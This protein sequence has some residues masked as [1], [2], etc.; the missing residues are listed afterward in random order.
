MERQLGDAFKPKRVIFPKGQ[1]LELNPPLPGE[2]GKNISVVS[3]VRDLG[4][5]ILVRSGV[6][7]RELAGRVVPV[8]DKVEITPIDLSGMP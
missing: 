4:K 5:E 8:P 3:V 7:G 1:R 6:A 2:D